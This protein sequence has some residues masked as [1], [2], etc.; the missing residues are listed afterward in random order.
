MSLFHIAIRNI[1]RNINNYFLYFISMAGSIMIFYT[2]KSIQ[3]NKQIMNLSKISEKIENAFILMSMVIAI[4]VSVFIW[5]S[6]AF[7]AGK[8]KKEIG[9]YCLMGVKKKHAARML[10]YENLIMGI[11]ALIVGIIIGIMFSKLFAMILVN[12]MGFNVNLKITVN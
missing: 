10:F 4:F 8:R 12:L 2:L 1:K 11:V 5:Y 9:L 7:F 3:Y 6:N